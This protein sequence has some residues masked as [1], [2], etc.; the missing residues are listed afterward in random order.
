M[1]L[2]RMRALALLTVLAA[3]LPLGTLAQPPAATADP[4]DRFFDDTVLHDI[5][6]TCNPRDWAS[7]KANFLD[8]TYYI[9]DFRW[10]DQTVRNIGIRSRG[11]GSRSGVKPGMRFDFDRYTTAQK[12][13]GLKSIVLRNNTQ[14]PSGIRERLAML[15][16]RRMGLHAPHEAHARLF[17]DNAYVGLYTIVESIDKTWLQKNY[18]EDDGYLYEF[19]YDNRAVDPFVFRYLGSD[20]ALYVPVPFKPE[21]HETAPRAEEFERFIW[22]VDAIGDAGWRRAMEEFLDLRAFITHLAIEN[23]LAEEDGITGDYG[24]NN[25]Y[26]YRFENKR[27]LAIIPWDKSNTF[28]QSDYS[29]FRNIDDGPLSHQNRLA[30]RALADPELRA[31]YLDTI[32]KCAD[33]ILADP[34][35]TPASGVV[36]TPAPAGAPGWLEVEIN[37]QYAQIHAAGLEDP[38]KPYTNAEFEDSIA[39]LIE[40][41]R[42]RSEF[43]RQQVARDRALR[44]IRN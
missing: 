41:A 20:P 21:T 33:S 11:T 23:F 24:P 17:V 7:L 10:N 31:L 29:I 27:L 18:G 42:A 1:L 36:L 6:L 32:L 34:S 4:A 14:D 12:F 38:V 3:A 30:T 5:R 15:M 19:A 44:G 35:L 28:W 26:I 40:F 25:F 37:R 9:C 43:V 2:N 39:G 16:F 22:T 13:L 8:D